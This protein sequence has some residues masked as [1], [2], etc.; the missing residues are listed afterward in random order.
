MHSKVAVRNLHVTRRGNQ[1]CC[2]VFFMKKKMQKQVGCFNLRV[3]T[4]VADK[5]KRQWVCMGMYLHK[6]TQ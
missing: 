5:L 2:E 6:A 3:V 1:G 4:M